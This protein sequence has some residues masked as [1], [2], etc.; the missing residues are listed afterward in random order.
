MHLVERNNYNNN[1]RYACNWA[2][3]QKNEKSTMI[4]RHVTCK[5]C[6]KILQKK[7]LKISAGGGAHGASEI[8]L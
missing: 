6:L 2:V 7:G 1:M 8:Q 5:N 4:S 3:I